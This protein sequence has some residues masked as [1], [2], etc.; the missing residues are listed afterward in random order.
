MPCVVLFFSPACVIL[1]HFY[2]SVLIQLGIKHD[3]TAYL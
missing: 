2:M 1:V 3:G